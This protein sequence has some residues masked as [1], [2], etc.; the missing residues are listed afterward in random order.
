MALIANYFVNLHSKTK[1]IKMKIS[2]IGAGAMGGT[3]VEGF[4]K[5]KNLQKQDICVAAPHESTL[6]RFKT[7]GVKNTTDNKE[8]AKGADLVCV[9]VKPW[10]TEDVLHEIKDTLDYKSQMLIV[11]SAGTPSTQLSQWLEKPGE[12]TLPFFQTIPNIAI[13]I[14]QSMTFIVPQGATAEQTKTVEDLFNQ[15]GGALIVAEK[16]LGA[17]TT[18][19]SCGIAY[20]LRYVRAA[21]EGGVEL[22]FKAKDAERIVSQ[23]VK[24][25]VDLLM[26]TDCHPE[27]LIDQVTTPGGLTIKGLNEM[28]HAGFTSAV[29]RGLKAGVK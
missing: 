18:L 22:G 24:G 21:S 9:V 20:A 11:V 3:M 8:A 4:A 6:E 16:Q 13:S 15:T 23:T 25:A 12:Q 7:L 14:L 1:T 19:A 17:G 10:I 28:E 2:V 27:S 5:L 26:Q 29:I